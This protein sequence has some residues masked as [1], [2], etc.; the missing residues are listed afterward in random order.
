MIILIVVYEMWARVYMHCRLG[1]YMELH[2]VTLYEDLY[3]VAA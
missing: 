2:D 1:A 3:F